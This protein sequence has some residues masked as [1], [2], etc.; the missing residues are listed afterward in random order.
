MDIDQANQLWK[1][2]AENSEN[3]ARAQALAFSYHGLIRYWTEVSEG[4]ASSTKGPKEELALIA[5]TM[6]ALKK[7]CDELNQ[8]V[9]RAED[10]YDNIMRQLD[11]ETE[12]G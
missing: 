6:G 3:R 10:E 2:A 7:R 8:Y 11:Y 4:E 9:I 5:S 1:R 12:R